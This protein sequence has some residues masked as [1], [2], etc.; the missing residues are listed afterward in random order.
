VAGGA[1]EITLY[2]PV[3]CED[4]NGTGYRGRLVITEVLN[5]TDPIR[6]AVLEHATAT[7]IQR[8]A[9]GEGMLTMY[10]D[11]LRKAV[12]GRTTMEE[13]LRVAEET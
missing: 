7:E 4:C 6:R 13:V 3:G 11:G 12:E 8:I 10:E 5:M 1:D 9:I 2:H